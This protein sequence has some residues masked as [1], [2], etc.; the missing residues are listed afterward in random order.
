MPTLNELASKYGSQHFSR[1][2]DVICLCQHRL[3]SQGFHDILN[4][5]N[6]FLDSQ[7]DEL[8]SARVCFY[9][10]DNYAFEIKA[11]GIAEFWLDDNQTFKMIFTVNYL[12]SSP[13]SIPE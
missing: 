13:I 7:V 5:F 6:E 4:Q 2:W 12:T 3:A 11:D 1:V 8:I 9:K 10:S